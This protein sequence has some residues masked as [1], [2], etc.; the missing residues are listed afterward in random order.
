MPNED[1]AQYATA[2]KAVDDRMRIDI[3]GPKVLE[4]LKDYS[5]VKEHVHEMVG[6]AIENHTDVKKKLTSF[7]KN[8]NTHTKGAVLEK[9]VWIIVGGAVSI[10]LAYLAL[11]LLGLHIEA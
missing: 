5:P 4:V 7:I 3:L 1:D 9:I 6:E 11:H 2:T 8:H 10:G